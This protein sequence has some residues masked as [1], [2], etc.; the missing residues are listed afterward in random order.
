MELDVKVPKTPDRFPREL[1]VMALLVV[2]VWGLWAGQAFFIPISLAALVA[3]LTTPLVRWMSKYKIP[4]WLSIVLSGLLLVLPFAFAGFMLIRQAQSLLQD[5]P[6]IVAQFQKWFVSF[7][8]SEIAKSL[9]LSEKLTMPALTEHLTQG[10]G[11]GIQ[12]MVKVLR[13]AF[14]AGTES[15]L[16]FLFAIIMLASRKHLFVSGEKILARYENIEAGKVLEAVTSLIEKF[17]LTK[18]I[19]ILIVGLLSF[20][21]LQVLGL[22]Y[23]FLLGMLSGVLTLIPEVGFAVSLLPVFVVAASTGHS[24]LSHGLIFGCLI[25]V[26][27]IEANILTPKLVGKNLN[28]NILATF[29]GLFAGG[30]LW[31]VW[32]MLLSVPIL[33]VLRIIF[34][35]APSLQPWAE[36]LSEREDRQMMLGLMSKSLRY[37]RMKNLLLKVNQSKLSRLKSSTDETF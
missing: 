1:S 14:E 5:Y 3:C 36:L 33:G 21:V 28:L 17:L 37:D 22:K 26:H 7:S 25:V 16:I 27:L 10:A 2:V 30:L 29:M 35:A 12:F 18:L 6:T 8:D 11:E 32:G 4:E 9:H 19:V 20:G 31:G 23:A 13:T 15:V 34:L 24:L